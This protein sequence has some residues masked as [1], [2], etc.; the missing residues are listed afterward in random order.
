VTGDEPSEPDEPSVDDPDVEDVDGLA[1]VTRE[2]GA[3][4]ISEIEHG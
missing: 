3:R 2:L 4:T 1:L